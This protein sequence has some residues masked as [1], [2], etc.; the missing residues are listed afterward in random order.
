MATHDQWAALADL[1]SDEE[2]QDAI[3]LHLTALAECPPAA[4]DEGVR[5]LL[6]AEGTRSAI[7]QQLLVLGRFRA[8]LTMPPDAVVALAASIEGARMTLGGPAAMGSA[9]ADR[10]AGRE[11]S[12]DDA[13]RLV[14]MLPGFRDQLPERTL[15]SLDMAAASRSGFRVSGGPPVLGTTRGPVHFGRTR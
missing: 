5:R 4:R 12:V 6:L 11:L 10:R 15:A 3:R 1:D 9:K 8:W 2:R 13:A 7:K 14:A